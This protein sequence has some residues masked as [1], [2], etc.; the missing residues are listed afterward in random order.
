MH[1]IEAEPTRFFWAGGYM[2]VSWKNEGM[3]GA[4]PLP[5]HFGE[6]DVAAPFDPERYF[7]ML[8]YS[9]YNPYLLRYGGRLTVGVGLPFQGRS[10]SRTSQRRRLAAYAWADAKDPDSSQIKSYIK[11]IA[12]KKPDGDF[13]HY[14]C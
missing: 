13:I 11:E 4:S 6:I 1:S 14:L 2:S 3:F 8:R 9:G 5:P 10:L 7:Q 12:M